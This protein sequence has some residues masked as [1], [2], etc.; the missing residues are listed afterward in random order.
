M[1]QWK[2]SGFATM[3]GSMPHK[4][5]D[6]VVEMIFR[7]FPEIPVW[8]QLPTYSDEQM[9][10]QYLE[11]L[12]GV[13]RQEDRVF[14]DT[15]A[16]GFDDELYK[17]YEEFLEVEG[18]DGSLV[19]SRFGMGEK[20]GITFF[21]FI[22]KLSRHSSHATA[23]K[24]QIIGPFTLLSGM[25]DQEGR[26]LLYDER[27]QDVMV[28]L[29]AMKARWQVEHLKAA[30]R[31]VIIF[32]DEPAL[33][34]FGSSAFISITRELI[35]QLLKEVVDSIHHS[36]AAAGIHICANTDWLLAFN[37]GVDIINLDAYTYFDKFALYK[38]DFT[39][40]MKKGGCVA[41]GM[42]PTNDPELINRET[43]QGLATRWLQGITGFTSKDLSIPDI[44]SQS[45]FTPSCGCG[46]LTEKSAE[47]VL[48]MTSEIGQILRAQFLDSTINRS[49]S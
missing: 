15:A 45:L 42:V 9:M 37:S 26:A 14:V 1:Q 33:A 46:S 47:K 23:V 3:V 2:A 39:D 27:M 16:P 5:R 17:F 12:P 40:F 31:P 7:Y 35:L 34:G 48:Q 32:L 25:K 10:N 38:E 22:D 29:L 28:K 24:G 41:W 43:A 13:V 21:H 20:T 49:P 6:T 19:N 18:S 36:G 30:G 4:D 8:P 11:G 44:L